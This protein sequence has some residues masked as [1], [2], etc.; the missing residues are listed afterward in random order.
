MLNGDHDHKHYGIKTLPNV[1][2]QLM[3]NLK[4]KEVSTKSASLGSFLIQ[5][6]NLRFEIYFLEFLNERRD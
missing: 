6:S 5:Y 4:T 2:Y 1:S 3:L